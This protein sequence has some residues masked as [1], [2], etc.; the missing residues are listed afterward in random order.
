MIAIA[1]ILSASIA[2]AIMPE[3]IRYAT[4]NG[5]FDTLGPRKIHNGKIPRLG[6]IAVF[7]AYIVTIAAFALLASHVVVDVTPQ[8][9]YWP[10]LVGMLMMFFLGLADDIQNLKALLK[11]AIQ[12]LAA[13]LVVG[14]GFRFSFIYVPFGE[15]KIEFGYMAWPLTLF[16]IVGITNA[17]NLIDGLD[18]LAGGIAAIASASFGIFYLAKGSIS[19]AVLCFTLS[20]TAVGFLQFN[21]PKASIFMGDA[22]SLFIGFTLAVLP[23]LNQSNEYSEIGIISS[24]T[25]L[26]IPILDTLA[27]IW[28]RTRDGVHFFTPDKGHIHHLLLVRGYGIWKILRIL[29]CASALLSLSALSTLV[30]SVPASSILKIGSLVA[31]VCVYGWLRSSTATSRKV[32]PEKTVNLSSG[33]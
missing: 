11:L 23:L 18:G 19:S 20:G 5:L 25:I 4:R 8:A 31:L 13:A 28:R 6:G 17:I 32:A 26:G 33:D 14:F 7:V 9:R 1:I 30:F 16:W 29:Y 10:I 22:G 21:W 2:S 3:I 24:I 27:A 12:L 15:G